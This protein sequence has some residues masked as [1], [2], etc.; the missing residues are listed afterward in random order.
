M[1][2]TITST[3]PELVTFS[4]NQPNVSTLKKSEILTCFPTRTIFRKS[5]SEQL[6][7][8]NA[9]AV[10]LV[11]EIVDLRLKIANGADQSEA[12]D[13]YGDYKLTLKQRG[14]V[15]ELRN[16]YADESVNVPSCEFDEAARAWSESVIGSLE[17]KFPEL[18]RN[19]DYA[20]IKNAITNLWKEIEPQ[21]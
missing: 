10:G 16:E 19:K 20:F 8:D 5:A 13:F 1:N 18:S 4:P 2:L 14:S 6:A 3:A 15:F 17:K 7:L 21:R 12:V 9:P 11:L